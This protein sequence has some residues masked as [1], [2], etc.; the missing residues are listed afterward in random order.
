MN[1]E[2]YYILVFRYNSIQ[3]FTEKDGKIINIDFANGKNSLSNCVALSYDRDDL[4]FLPDGDPFAID[5][6]SSF[7]DFLDFGGYHFESEQAI[8]AILKSIIDKKLIPNLKEKDTIFVCIQAFYFESDYSKRNRSGSNLV[9]N[10]EKM[11][12]GKHNIYCYDAYT[13]LEASMRTLKMALGNNFLLGFPFV[14][15]VVKKFD[16]EGLFAVTLAPTIERTIVEKVAERHPM[17]TNVPEKLL[18]NVKNNIIVSKLFSKPLPSEAIY[19]NRRIDIGFSDLAKHFDEI[20][21]EDSR[22]FTEKVGD[23]DKGP[24][25]VFDLGMHPVLKEA[26][27]SHMKEPVFVKEEDNI[28]FSC[29][30]LRNL[31]IEHTALMDLKFKT[32]ATR[33]RKTLEEKEAIYRIGDQK[34]YEIDFIREYFVQNGKKNPLNN[35]EFKEL[36]SLRPKGTEN[37]N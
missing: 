3:L 11:K 8:E 25:L 21:D 9:C 36:A 26:F 16:E 27:V 37:D 24:T 32:I 15:G 5:Q 33:E 13:L 34:Y 35:L 6:N 17:P 18:R 1:K 29:F 4:E 30:M 20:L 28:K 19:Q 2:N 10:F 7:S 23:I 22:D 31:I 12:I 14:T